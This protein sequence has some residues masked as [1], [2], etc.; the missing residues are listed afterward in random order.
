M[1]PERWQQIEKLYQSVRERGPAVLADTEPGLR[2]EVESLLAQASRRDESSTVQLAPGPEPVWAGQTVSHYRIVE[3]LGEGG[4]GV[5][6][7][8]FDTTLGRLVALKFLPPHLRH[9]RELKTRLAEEARAAS[10]LDHPNVVV[11]YEIDETQDGGLFIAMALHEGVTLRQRMAAGLP[12]VEALQIARQIA[13]GLAKA[14]EAGIIHRDI[15]PSN[16]IVASD[17]IARIIDFGLAKSID[18]TAT[19]DGSAKGTPLYMSPEQASAEAV[20]R[21]TDLWSLGAVLF[22]MLANRPPFPGD[23]E[24]QVMQ[25]I[26]HQPAPRLRDIRPDLP[27]EIDAIISRALEK[28]RAK[29]YQSAANMVQDLA[30]VLTTLH[31]PAPQRSRLRSAYAAAA[32]ALILLAAGSS[33]W[34]Y[35]RSEQRHWAREQAIPQIAKLAEKQPLAAFVLWRRAAQILPGDAQLAQLARSFTV[36]GSVQTTPSGAQVEIQD[37]LAPNGAWLSLGT[38]P[39][40]NVERPQ[41]YFRWRLSR[42]GAPVFVAA[43]PS[44][45]AM[46]FFLPERDVP[47][48]MVPVPGGQAGGMIDF[49]GW[50]EYRLPAFDIDQF[51]V[52]NAQFQTFVDQGGYRKPEYWKETFVKDGKKL[53][54]GQAM[55]LFRDPTGRSG[56]STWEGG[57]FPPAQG[58]YPVSGVSWYE[59]AAY[60]EFS[61]KS[62][63]AI[64][65]WYK[66]APS[67]LADASINQGN[68]SGRGPTR[69]G[70]SGEVGPYGTYDMSGNVREWCLNM[71]DDQRFIL[72][73]A[74]RTQTYQAYDP[75]ALPP[76]DRSDLNGIR[77]VRNRGPLPADAVAPLIRQTR[78]FSTAKP[79]ADDVFQAYRTMY[80]YDRTPVNPQNESVVENTPDWTREKL[81]IDAGY[82]NERLP[83]YL[84]LPKNVPPP[85]QAVVFFPSARVNAMPA[86]DV[87]GDLQFVDYVIKS[88]RALIYPIYKGTY[89]RTGHRGRPGDFGDL[90]LMIQDSREVRRAVDYLQTRPDIDG[91]KIA[92]LGVSQGT[93]DGVIYTALEDRFKTVVFLDGGFFLGPHLAARDQVNF[94]P[95]LKKPVLMVNGRY[96]FTFSPDRAQDPLFRMLGTPE[97]DKRHILFD[98]PHD[99]SQRRAD[100]S[101]EV[102]AWLDKYLGRVN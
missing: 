12:V 71:V 28:D 63:P 17:G 102:L 20:D 101:R 58:D 10:T 43:P 61:G 50:L 65:Q 44:S 16:I 47:A 76:F 21:R 51:E 82:E 2:G 92:Y 14:H 32:T 11:I 55:D 1:T 87:L 69:V 80:A 42:P 18:A 23:R 95:R 89:E 86:S 46:R 85:Y 88:G 90:N 75:E 94:A 72:G 68:F 5:V 73:G 45:A 57:H 27:P 96:D 3:K 8:A 56:P 7:K 33:M 36:T 6:Y 99:I 40:K 77:L 93:A 13:S 35:R 34:F 52:T 15:K 37:Y 41:G 70:T 84:F 97:A 39:L 78:D 81:T 31:A 91:S 48:G 79:V 64:T 49:I 66:A 22:E 100:L 62:L 38:T 26:V 59:A 83:V 60:A 53:A 29:R 30:A 24:L 54:W 9:N 74:W 67:D 25:A 19:L 4:M 98:T